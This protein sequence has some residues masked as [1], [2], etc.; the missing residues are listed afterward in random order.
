MVAK[1][2]VAAAGY[3]SFAG[4][5]SIRARGGGAVG[6]PRVTNAQEMWRAARRRQALLGSVRRAVLSLSDYASVVLFIRGLY[7]GLYERAHIIRYFPPRRR[8]TRARPSAVISVASRLQ[9][10]P[11]RIRYR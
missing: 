3:A 4:D 11:C 1:A 7:G 9:N 5:I 8:G 10:L 6:A 2:A